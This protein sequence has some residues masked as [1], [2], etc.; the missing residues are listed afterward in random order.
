MGGELG[1]AIADFEVFLTAERGLSPRTVE[2]YGRDLRQLA[3]YLAEAG[4]TRPGELTRERV[5]GFEARLHRAGVMASSVARKVSAIRTFLA[6]A[7]R[8]GYL[9]GG[10]PEIDSP[11][12]PR[13]LPKMLS[14]GEIQALLAQPAVETAEGLRDRAILELMYASGL[15]VSEAAT[16]RLEAVQLEA[17]LVRCFGK[18]SKERLVPFHEG[19][20]AWLERYLKESRPELVGESR[21][22]CFFVEAGGRPLSR[23]EIWRRVRGYA[24][25]AGL[26]PVSPHTLR[27]SFATH[28]LQGGADLRAIQEM[29]GHASIATT[30]IY[31]AVDDSH[32]AATFERFHP[33]A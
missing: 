15:R 2:A 3:G 14:R 4:W 25:R 9:E 24:R 18:G 27:H 11:R 10:P 20:A 26:P 21:P 22:E 32:L 7:H 28:L 30:Q 31:T 33:R 13:R 17:R 16:L 8:E 23:Q 1:A 12:K 29:L 19:A 5:Y 6:F